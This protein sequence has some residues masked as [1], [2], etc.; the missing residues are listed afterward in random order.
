L[1]IVALSSVIPFL[2]VAL[3]NFK[4]ERYA[5]P[6]FI[7]M[8]VLAGCGLSLV[9]TRYRWLAGMTTCVLLALP[10]TKVAV[11]NALLP[12]EVLNQGFALQSR[13]PLIRG[14]ELFHYVRPP[15]RR[16]WQTAELVKA[17]KRD[18]STIGPVFIVGVSPTFHAALLRFATLG[19]GS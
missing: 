3:S 13:V 14:L 10:I 12:T 2:I 4:L 19:S 9:W 17:T 11:T 18:G 5:Y 6:G 1:A 7:G 8:F 15:D 16:N